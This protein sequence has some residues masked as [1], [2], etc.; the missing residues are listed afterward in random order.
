MPVVNGLYKS[1]K[2][3][4]IFLQKKKTSPH[5]LHPKKSHP[6]IHPSPK[7]NNP[8]QKTKK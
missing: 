1:S 3:I 7:N 6:H 8:T 5:P 4:F 2:K